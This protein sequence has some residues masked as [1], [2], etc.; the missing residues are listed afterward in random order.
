MTGAVL[1]DI[2]SAFGANV[3]LE[4]FCSLIPPFVGVLC[5]YVMYYIGKDYGG[6]TVGLLAALFLAVEPTIIER[7]S[8]GFFDTQVVGT[9]ALV[10]FIFLF[11]RSL[12]ANRSFQGLL[13]YSLSAGA[14]LAY[15]IGGWGGAYYIIDLIALFAFIMI[16]IRRYSQRLLISYGTTF[17]LGLFIAT[18][19]P[20]ISNSYLISYS[21][22]PVAAVL[23]SCFWQRF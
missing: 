1:Y 7:T 15:F 13:A 8:L 17:G 5:V 4:T 22:L 23:F 19:I 3:S 2:F 14:A 21:V 11:L 6:R 12:D 20:Y 16:I 9:L 18:K 10:L